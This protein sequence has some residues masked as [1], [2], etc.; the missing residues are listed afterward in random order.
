VPPDRQGTI[1]PLQFEGVRQFLH[2]RTG[3]ALMPDKQ[4]FVELRLAMVAEAH[5]FATTARLLE[6]LRS[7]A[8]WGALHAAVAE[9]MAVTETSFFRDHHPFE[10]LR[11]TLLPR[12]IAR[13]AATRT[14]TIWCA[15][16]ASGQEPYSLA[17]LIREHFPELASWRVRLIATDFS[18]AMLA[19]CRSGIYSQIEVNRGLPVPY[20]V[21]YFTQEGRSWR[22]RE[23]LRAMLE[24]REL[25]LVQPWPILP[26]AD[27]VLMRNVLIYFDAETCRRILL[28]TGEVLREDG[29][30]LLGGSE[31]SLPPDAPFEPCLHG[32]TLV[33][34]PRVRVA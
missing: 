25:N 26:A 6:S 9:G 21:K 14:L 20:L 19:R 22:I 8:P 29:Y 31:S 33:Q 4:Y 32:R 7:E 34:H 18:K 11:N 1:L 5:G 16:V 27:L 23:D 2:D 3:I 17:M 10:E 15:S 30:L 12:L 24:L 13:R 28:K